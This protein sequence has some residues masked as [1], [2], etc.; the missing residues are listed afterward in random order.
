M[1]SVGISDK[2]LKKAI[3]I[4]GYIEKYDDVK[5]KNLW[6]KS[7]EGIVPLETVYKEMRSKLQKTRFNF[8]VLNMD[9]I[10]EDIWKWIQKK[11]KNFINKY[12]T[13]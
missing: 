8:I 4:T 10:I 2:T 1:I 5:I 9:I 6:K 7:L 11:Y 12:T 13:K 3:K